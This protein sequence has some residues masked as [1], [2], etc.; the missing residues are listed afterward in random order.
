MRERFMINTEM[1]IYNR[2]ETTYIYNFI[3]L[4]VNL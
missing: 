4:D 3:N 1:E 2:L